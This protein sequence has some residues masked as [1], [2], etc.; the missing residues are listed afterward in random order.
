MTYIVTEFGKPFTAAGFGNKFRDWCDEGGLE[1]CAAHGLRKAG[2]T[3]AAD[4]GAT[5][6]QL[7]AIY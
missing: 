6:H 5:A 2:A 1:G 3:I 4:N 7:M